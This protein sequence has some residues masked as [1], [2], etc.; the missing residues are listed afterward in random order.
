MDVG[1]GDDEEHILALLDRDSH[2][3]GDGFHSKL[4]HSL[5]RLLLVTVLLP[6]LRLV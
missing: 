5:S 6:A 3:R 4:L 1:L 2:D